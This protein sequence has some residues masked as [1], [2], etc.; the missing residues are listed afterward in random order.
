MSEIKYMSAA[1]AA[2]L[3]ENGDHIYIQGSTS[4]LE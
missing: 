4:I 1:E 2:R 3:I